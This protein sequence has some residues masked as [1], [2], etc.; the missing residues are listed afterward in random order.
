MRRDPLWLPVLHNNKPC[1]PWQQW[2]KLEWHQTF[3]HPHDIVVRTAN[4]VGMVTMT[5]ARKLGHHA[6]AASA[7]ITTT[8]AVLPTLS[9]VIWLP[10]WCHPSRLVN[11]ILKTWCCPSLMGRN[12]MPLYCNTVP[13]FAVLVWSCVVVGFSS[14][15]PLP[16]ETSLWLFFNSDCC[17]WIMTVLLSFSLLS[18]FLFVDHG[19]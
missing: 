9:T 16:L 1:F 4:P 6:M 15:S 12:C 19:G 14:V 13:C 10:C 8:T 2:E 3:R 7:L 17:S 11:P 18:L 5:A